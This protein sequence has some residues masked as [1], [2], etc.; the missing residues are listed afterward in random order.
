MRLLKSGSV[1]EEGFSVQ[2]FVLRSKATEAHPTSK[3]AGTPISAMRLREGSAAGADG[4]PEF[5]D[6]GHPSRNL[7]RP[8]FHAFGEGGF[9][10]HCSGWRNRAV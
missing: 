3:L 9:K 6:L 2:R 5:S 7:S 10:L 1:N 8:L 4:A